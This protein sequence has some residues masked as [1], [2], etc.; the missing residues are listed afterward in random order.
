LWR[1]HTFLP[2]TN[3]SSVYNTFAQTFY[4]DAQLPSGAVA[5]PG[6]DG[7]TISNSTYTVVVRADSSTT[8]VYYNIAGQ[9]P[10][11]R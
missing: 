8:G 9:Q 10:E 11:Q 1:A 6:V 5:S 2:R 3:K 4:Y 7:S